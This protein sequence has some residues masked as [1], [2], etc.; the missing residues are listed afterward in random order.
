MHDVLIT[1][2]PQAQRNPDGTFSG[3][4]LP[5]VE[6]EANAIQRAFGTQRA[7]KVS[8]ISVA[9]LGE[10][11]QG[12]QIWFFPGHGDAMLQGEPVLA[13]ERD[14]R[15]EAVSID[16]LVSTV[17]PHAESGQLKL[18]VLTGCKT[19]RLGA[20][21]HERAGVRDVVCWSTLLED[22]AGACFGEAFATSTADQLLEGRLD[23]AEAF[24]AACAAVNVITEPGR[25]GRRDAHVQKFELFVDPQDEEQVNP[26]TRRLRTS[27]RMPAGVP[28]HLMPVASPSAPKSFR[29]KLLDRL[30]TPSSALNWDGIG[31][32]D[33]LGSGS[34]GRTFRV[35]CEALGL[36]AAKRLQVPV[37]SE[38]EKALTTLRQEASILATVHHPNVVQL[39]GV[40]TD[41]PERWCLLLELAPRGNLRQWLDREAL[42]EA[43]Q[44]TVIQG[45]A[46]GMAALHLRMPPILHKDL[47]ASNVL[48][49]DD[50]QPKLSDFG[51]AT[52]MGLGTSLGTASHGGRGTFQYHAPEL[53]DDQP[54][55]GACDVYAFG[56]LM[57]ELGNPRRL[58]P[59]AGMSP[60]AVL[61]KLLK[62]GRPDEV[63]AA[64]GLAGKLAVWTWA[65]DASARPTFAEIQRRCE[66]PASPDAP[67]ED[68]ARRMTA[69]EAAEAEVASRRVQAQESQRGEAADAQ[70]EGGQTE[71]WA[72]N[73]G[74]LFPQIADAGP[75]Y[76]LEEGVKARI[77]APATPDAAKQMTAAKAVE[78]EAQVE[79]AKAHFKSPA[80]AS[81]P[82]GILPVEHKAQTATVEHWVLAEDLQQVTQERD[83]AWARLA[84]LDK[85]GGGAHAN[86]TS[87]AAGP[88]AAQTPKRSNSF[89][90]RSAFASRFRTGIGSGN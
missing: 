58:T 77:E 5:N 11:L 42:D 8:R 72:G 4:H 47:K 39:H 9:Q 50:W 20:A 34:F 53:F 56:V 89:E 32:D 43:A 88:S 71:E 15:I 57:W 44:R 75:V 67:Q 29:Q 26:T 35:Q 65:Q 40:S 76:V 1:A 22:E 85:S 25:V 54:F 10:L 7:K 62:G 2:E 14:E 83:E 59:W 68:A 64:T 80:A 81:N 33:E 82:W 66:A 84:T 6:P 30:E 3:I 60:M 90:R 52:Q 49:F 16:A 61:G 63:D 27:G 48:I 51:L 79:A 23:P 38:R 12:M 78:A 87:S 45:I 69:A 86:R 46:R 18:V 37:P 36:I 74:L 31:E 41:D 13:F 24:G 17:R 55:T 21:L 19:E 73:S 70:V 28:V